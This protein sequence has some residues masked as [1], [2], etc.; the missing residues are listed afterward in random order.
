MR[1]RFG[2]YCEVCDDNDITNTQDDRSTPAMCLGPT[3]NFQ[4]TYIFFNLLTGQVVKQRNFKVLSY[5][6]RMID[7]VNEWGQKNKQ[8][9]ELIFKNRNNDDFSWL[10]DDE[11]SELDLIADNAVE[12]QQAPHCS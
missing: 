12:V 4:G 2:A 8:E 6:D 11:D 9:N 7:K 5:P 1:A 10:G 3:G